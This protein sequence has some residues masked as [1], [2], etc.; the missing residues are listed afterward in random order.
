[1]D[2]ALL[3]FRRT[4]APAAWLSQR[5]LSGLSAGL[6]ERTRLVESC[7]AE[8]AWA[9]ADWLEIAGAAADDDG[10]QE[11]LLPHER[12]AARLLEL[13]GRLHPIEHRLREGLERLAKRRRA[14][15]ACAATLAD[16]EAYRRDRRLLLRALLDAA[17]DY[18]HKR[19]ALAAECRTLRPAA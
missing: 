18:R 16:V 10:W 12:A 1:M 3:R 5:L 17:V 15:W 19:L 13:W 14:R 7:R 4:A 8:L 9:R 2:T 6:G 11:A